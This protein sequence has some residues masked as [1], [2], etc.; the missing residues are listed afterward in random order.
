MRDQEA[1]NPEFESPAN[2]LPWYGRGAVLG[3]YGWL[4]ITLVLSYVSGPL[5]ARL[6]YLREARGA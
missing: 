3:T 1:P 5:V 2:P 4:L 6:D